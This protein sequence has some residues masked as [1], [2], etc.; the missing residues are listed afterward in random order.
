M[1][2]YLHKQLVILKVWN[3]YVGYLISMVHDCVVVNTHP[4]VGDRFSGGE[5]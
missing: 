3:A 5:A 1:T 2:R 4:A